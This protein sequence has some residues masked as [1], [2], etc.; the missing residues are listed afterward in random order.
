MRERPRWNRREPRLTI[1]VVMLLIAGAAVGLWLALDELRRGDSNEFGDSPLERWV[2]G[3][4]FVLGGLSLVGPPLLL[5]TARRR[6]WGAGRFLWFTQGTSA[7]LLW[8]PA[9]PPS[10]RA[11][12]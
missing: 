1:G 6:Y 8:P 9:A 3:V 2:L 10:P 12:K 7:W 11:K 4:V 5:L